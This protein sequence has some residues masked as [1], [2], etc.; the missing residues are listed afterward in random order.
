MQEILYGETS[1]VG[2]KIIISDNAKQFDNDGFKLFYLNLAISH[3]FS[4]LGHPQANGQVKVTNRMILRNLKERLEKSKR[5]WTEDLRSILCAYHT[6]SKIP[7]GQTSFFMVYGTELVILVKIEIPSFR[8]SI[9]NKE[10]NKTELRLNL[11]LLG[12]KREQAKVRQAAYKYQVSNYYNQRVKH[13]FFLLG[14]LVLR[15]VTMSTK[16]LNAGKIGPTW[17]G[18]YKVVK[19]SRSGMY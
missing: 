17:E 13:R 14:D 2:L 6:T 11:D 16:E 8:T 1:S 9:F 18:P 10:N 15:N 5:E 4:L 7:T 12:E 3:H 19:V